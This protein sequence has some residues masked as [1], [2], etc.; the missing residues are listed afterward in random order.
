MHIV[1]PFPGDPLIIKTLCFGGE[2]E[3]HLNRKSLIAVTSDSLIC[4]YSGTLSSRNSRVRT[5][6]RRGEQN[7]LLTSVE[8]SFYLD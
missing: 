3:K 2:F 1:L 7:P 4:R 6:L 5:F 8:I